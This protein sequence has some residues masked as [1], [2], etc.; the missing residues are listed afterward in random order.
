MMEKLNDGDKTALEVC[1]EQADEFLEESKTKEF[2]KEEY[3]EKQTEIS[4]FFD[5][6]NQKLKS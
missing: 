6:L 3:D 2:T 4:D 5:P 1:I